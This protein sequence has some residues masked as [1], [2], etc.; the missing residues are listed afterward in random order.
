MIIRIASFLVFA[1]AM[2]ACSS[3]QGVM[4]RD[5]NGNTLFVTDTIKRKIFYVD[6]AGKYIEVK[7][8]NGLADKKDKLDS[9]IMQRQYDL[10]S[11]YGYNSY[12]PYASVVYSILFSKK[13]E[14]LEVRILKRESYDNNPLI[15]SIVIKSIIETKNIWREKDIKSKKNIVYFSR[16]R[17]AIP[18]T[19]SM[20]TFPVIE[21]INVINK[22]TEKKHHGEKKVRTNAPKHVK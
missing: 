17:V 11:E 10:W 6:N 18:E 7:T 1:F 22:D 13:M 2:W 9:L 16:I 5:A 8:I 19:L 12:E 21:G 20:G 3:S 14:I 15:D 4:S